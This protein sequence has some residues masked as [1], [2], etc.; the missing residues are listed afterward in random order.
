MWKF[1]VKENLARERAINMNN[2]QKWKAGIQESICTLLPNL[3]FNREA[4][5][6]VTCWK[7][8]VTENMHKILP[9]NYHTF[10]KAYSIVHVHFLLGYDRKFRS[11]RRNVI[12]NAVYNYKTLNDELYHYK[13]SL[14]D[15]IMSLNIPSMQKYE[16][17]M[18]LHF[19]YLCTMQ[20]KNILWLEKEI[21]RQSTRENR[22]RSTQKNHPSTCD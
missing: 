21:M 4:P 7:E 14:R 16:V 5:I 11:Q 15:H 20:V 13:R 8:T 12:W 10:L 3:N 2:L 17:P 9:E 6:I 18:A 19:M 1:S 22:E